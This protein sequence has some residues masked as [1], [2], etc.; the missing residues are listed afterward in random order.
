[1]ALL[2]NFNLSR[3][4]DF[5]AKL[6]AALAK[7]VNTEVKN[8]PKSDPN[9]AMYIRIGKTMLS[10]EAAHAIFVAQSAA[11]A[12]VDPSDDLDIQIFIDANFTTLA[13]M[14]DPDVPGTD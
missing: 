5:Q 10:A 2:D 4:G 3:D 1:V 12:G 14:F 11:A 13:K 7:K 8:I 6:I 9:Y